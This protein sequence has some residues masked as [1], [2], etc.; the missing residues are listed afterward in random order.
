MGRQ[1][2]EAFIGLQPN[3]IWLLNPLYNAIGWKGLLHGPTSIQLLSDF[4]IQMKPHKVAKYC[5]ILQLEIPVIELIIFL[6][7]HAR[8]MSVLAYIVYLLHLNVPKPYVLLNATLLL[9]NGDISWL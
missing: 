5:R 4:N 2:S 1:N 6:I 8:V 7:L 3:K 9:T